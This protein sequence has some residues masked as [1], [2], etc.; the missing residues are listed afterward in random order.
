MRTVVAAL[1]L[2]LG[3]GMAFAQSDCQ[4]PLIY[5]S[6][7]NDQQ[8]VE[9]AFVSYGYNNICSGKSAKTGLD[10]G[11]SATAIVDMLPIKSSMS[12]GLRKEKAEQFCKEQSDYQD[13]HRTASRNSSIVV[14]ESLQAFNI[15]KAMETAKVRMNFDIGTRGFAI[16]VARGSGDANFEGVV[17]TPATAAAC[18]MTHVGQDG[19]NLVEVGPST[20]FPL[21]GREVAITCDKNIVD[22]RI[23]GMEVQIK[24]SEKSMRLNLLPDFEYMPQYASQMREALETKDR[25]Y[26]AAFDQHQQRADS[27]GSFRA[28]KPTPIVMTGGKGWDKLEKCPAGHYVAGVGAR[29][30]GGGKYC[31]NCVE[32]VKFICEPFYPPAAT[33][34]Q[35]QA[36]R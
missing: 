20:V 10:F 2:V 29:G 1:V 19:G 9:E 12:F 17:I 8:S 4:S 32:T 27:V 28:D 35:A 23:P 34:V 30:G 26:R 16:K 5:A 14:R 11:S 31:Y 18:T 3:P 22:G 24:T 33:Q 13:M 25:E 21:T 36:Q 7:D 6:R 15:C